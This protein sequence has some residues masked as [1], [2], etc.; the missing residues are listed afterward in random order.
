MAERK[1]IFDW[2]TL[3]PAAALAFVLLLHVK[4]PVY[5]GYRVKLL[6]YFTDLLRIL[7]A[8]FAAYAL[9]SLFSERARKKLRYKVPFFAAGF[10]LLGLYNL[11]THKVNVLPGPKVIQCGYDPKSDSTNAF[12]GTQNSAFCRKRHGIRIQS[13]A[14][15]LP[16][17][18]KKLVFLQ[19]FVPAAKN[20]FLAS[21]VRPVLNAVSASLNDDKI[22][23][24]LNNKTSV[25]K[26]PYTRG[27]KD[28]LKEQH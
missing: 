23:I 21:D 28:Y 7:I 24:T 8:V 1:I 19:N 17:G 18:R 5:S 25:Q 22:M 11:I 26:V 4:L 3:I 16:Q 6:P 10:L 14:V 27:A 20:E 15:N 13:L 2:R 12:R 9:V